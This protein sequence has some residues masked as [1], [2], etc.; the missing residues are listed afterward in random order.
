MASGAVGSV[1]VTVDVPGLPAEGIE[2]FGSTGSLP[3]DTPFPFYRMAS[4][5]LAYV[6][7]QVV[8][9]ILT[10]GDPYERQ[11]EAFAAAIRD[12]LAPNPEVRDGLPRAAIPPGDQP[13]PRSAPIRLPDAPSPGCTRSLRGQ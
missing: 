12:D 2:V 3:V 6:N 5:V 4:T 13:R 10:D 7:S 1:A 9:P 8:I 11:L